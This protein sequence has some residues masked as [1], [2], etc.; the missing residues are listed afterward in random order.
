[1]YTANLT[2]INQLIYLMVAL[3]LLERSGSTQVLRRTQYH[4]VSII[5]MQN[6]LLYVEITGKYIFMFFLM[7]LI[8]KNVSISLKIFLP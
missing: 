6:L 1:M 5:L 7:N 4:S 2:D 8:M 3:T